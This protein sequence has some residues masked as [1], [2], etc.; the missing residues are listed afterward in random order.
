MASSVSPC[1]GRDASSAATNNALVD[2]LY[3][4]TR[5]IVTS[6]HESY[7]TKLNLQTETNLQDQFF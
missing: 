7:E 2:W 5:K 3:T 1:T 4:P 6:Q